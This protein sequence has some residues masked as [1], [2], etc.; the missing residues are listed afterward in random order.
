MFKKSDEKRKIII[1][2]TK[3][4]DWLTVGQTCE[5]LEVLNP[6]QVR[7]K[8]GGANKTWV[9]RSNDIYSYEFVTETPVEIGDEI[10]LL[11]NTQSLKEGEIKKITGFVNNDKSKILVEGILPGGWINI[12]NVTI[13]KNPENFRFRTLGELMFNNGG[14]RCWGIIPNM[15]EKVFKS[16]P[17]GK[18]LKDV[19]AFRHDGDL[20]FEYKVENDKTKVFKINDCLIE[21]L[22][23]PIRNYDVFIMNKEQM[24]LT[25]GTT[26][27][28]WYKDFA[29]KG[30]QPLSSI[31]KFNSNIEETAF[32]LSKMARHGEYE[33]DIGSISYHLLQLKL[34]NEEN[35]IHKLPF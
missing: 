35:N 30:G 5:I 23:S 13:L 7:L 27:H 9:I 24:H 4:A 26:D 14:V 31:S 15:N 25:L 18:P 22:D 1:L 19:K 32:F 21:N 12:C 33:T 28:K 34:T 3:G 11:K 20:Y 17:F 29:E 10:F 2:D 6:E 8:D 16:I